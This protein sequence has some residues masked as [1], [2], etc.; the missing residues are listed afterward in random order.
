MRPAADADTI[1]TTDLT[2]D[3]VVDRIAALVDARRAA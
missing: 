1:D 3:E 2:A